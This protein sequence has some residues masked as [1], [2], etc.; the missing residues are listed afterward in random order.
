MSISSL[1][2]LTVSPLIFSAMVLEYIVPQSRAEADQQS[3]QTMNTC[4]SNETCQTTTTTCAN[5]EP[6]HTFVGNSTINTIM[7]EKVCQHI[8]LEGC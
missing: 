4:F 5:S 1:A 3:T 7:Q 6:C 8:N 2:M